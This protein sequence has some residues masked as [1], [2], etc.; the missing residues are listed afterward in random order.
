VGQFTVAP[1]GLALKGAPHFLQCL[2]VML[3]SLFGFVEASSSGV[4]TDR[5]S[6]VTRDAAAR[7]N[8][9][10]CLKEEESRPAV[11]EALVKRRVHVRRLLL[12]SG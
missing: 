3:S 10:R 11:P 8:A 1:A 6:L 5:A 4:E 2:I 7:R 9:R 12:G